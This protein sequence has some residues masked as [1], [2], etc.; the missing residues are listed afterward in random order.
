MV[1]TTARILYLQTTVRSAM[2][3]PMCSPGQG[4]VSTQCLALS[5]AAS[6][7]LFLP[8]CQST[9]RPQLLFSLP[10]FFSLLSRYPPC[11]RL[12][13]LF[14]LFLVFLL[15]APGFPHYPPLCFLSTGY[16]WKTAAPRSFASPSYCSSQRQPGLTLHPELVLVAPPLLPK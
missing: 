10:P 12:S 9:F 14:G 7:P 4:W 1:P 5:R 15:L 16:K 13:L 11:H 6:K 2:P 3:T 8:E